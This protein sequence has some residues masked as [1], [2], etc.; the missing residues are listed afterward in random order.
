MAG[1]GDSGH[2]S[3][4][5][6]S[7]KDAL[8]A[9][10][11]TDSRESNEQARIPAPQDIPVE[12]LK[13]VTEAAKQLDRAASEAKSLTSDDAKQ[14][15]HKP[16][17]PLPTSAAEAAREA[18]GGRPNIP[19]VQSSAK[20]IA[21]EPPTTRVVRDAN[22]SADDGDPVRTQL[23]R[24][25]QKVQRGDFKQDPVVGWL[26]IVG[27]PGLGSFRPIFEG[28]NTVGRSESNRVP[29]DFG[30]EAISN[31]EQAY[32]RYDSADRSFLL[33]PNLS[34]TNVVSVNEKRPTQ[35]V[36]LAAMDVI[37]MGRTQ[38]VFVPFCGPDFDWSDLSE[39]AR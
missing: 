26:V 4:F 17:P 39:L 5:L 19:P 24:G 1:R 7:L 14:A 13:D 31:E 9:A 6:G 34:K 30:D 28:N 12:S 2:S 29:I 25:K 16:P 33:V 22:V 27:G 38:L 18:R 11:R 37:T 8:A 15:G 32:I 23:V 10:S 20:P 35:A 3:S 36:P 21:S